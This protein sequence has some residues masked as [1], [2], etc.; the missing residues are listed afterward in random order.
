MRKFD[1]IISCW[2]VVLLVGL[3]VGPY[4]AHCQE[5]GAVSSGEGGAAPSGQVSTTLGVISP[6]DK[7]DDLNASLGAITSPSASSTS[8]SSSGDGDKVDDLNASLGAITSPS[9]SST[10]SSSSGDGDKVEDLNASLG[11]ISGG[12]GSLYDGK[13]SAG[14]PI[15]TTL[16]PQA[17]LSGP[18]YASDPNAN[19][20]GGAVNLM[21]DK[22]YIMGF[23]STVRESTKALQ[24]FGPGLVPIK[25]GDPRMSVIRRRFDKKTA[26]AY[27]ILLTAGNL[28]NGTRA[29]TINIG[30]RD[31]MQKLQK[32]PRN[33]AGELMHGGALPIAD[34]DLDG[35]R[36]T[37][38][39]GVP[40][41]VSYQ[42]VCGPTEETTYLNAWDPVANE[43][44]SKN[45][46]IR[47]QLLPEYTFF[48]RLICTKVSPAEAWGMQCASFTEGPIAQGE[49]CM[50]KPPNNFTV[51]DPDKDLARIVASEVDVSMVVNP[52]GPRS[53][54]PV[55]MTAAIGMIEELLHTRQSG[56]MGL[57][58]INPFPFKPQTVNI[59]RPELGAISGTP[60]MPGMPGMAGAPGT[61]G[62]MAPP[63]VPSS[64]TSSLGRKLLQQLGGS[65]SPVMAT[66]MQPSYSS[67]SPSA[68]GAPAL[69]SV[70]SPGQQQQQ[71]QPGEKV[72][73]VLERELE[74]GLVPHVPEQLSNAEG[75]EAISM[76]Q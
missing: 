67:A 41:F 36:R 19:F 4:V 2:A 62:V 68:S 15:S 75:L 1:T 22:S 47:P 70:S 40:E 34:L 65:P 60:G 69:G 12:G 43:C 46:E 24:A 31:L 72:G 71:Q 26:I 23:T 37:D 74:T 57:G 61:S 7:V 66:T 9:A 13:P 64:G 20:G 58:K 73:V 45:F 35:L 25:S 50:W 29:G 42:I 44:K 59:L 54:L 18:S 49:N 5:P 28:K 10:S 16:A 63:L 6:G 48:A 11:A 14:G 3:L 56:E 21:W 39:R 17:P 27:P 30:V 53:Q 52:T 51:G 8:S 38:T 76:C 33:E 55:M 32:M